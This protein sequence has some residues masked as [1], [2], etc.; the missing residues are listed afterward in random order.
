M[1][2]NYINTHRTNNNN[3]TS[4]LIQDHC[5]MLLQIG[6]LILISSHGN[7]SQVLAIKKLR[8][9]FQLFN[10]CIHNNFDVRRACF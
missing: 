5:Q 2:L 6:Y 9:T 7:H 10:T 3:L 4:K 1:H 8:N